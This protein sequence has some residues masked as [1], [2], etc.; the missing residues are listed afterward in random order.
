MEA[1]SLLETQYVIY[2]Q[3]ELAT[4]RIIELGDAAAGMSSIGGNLMLPTSASGTATTGTPGENGLG[5]INQGLLEQSN[6]SVV[7]EMVNMIATQRTY[8]MNSKVIATADQM[9]QFVTQNL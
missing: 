2:K 1:R 8:E 6:V 7:E 5:R 9:L 3:N 4:G